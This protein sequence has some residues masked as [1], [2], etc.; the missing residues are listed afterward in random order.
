MTYQ[1]FERRG[2]VA[3][4]PLTPVTLRGATRGDVPVV[5]IA[6]GQRYVT[7]AVDLLS[8]PATRTLRYELV[9]AGQRAILS[10]DAPLPLQGAPFML[11]VPAD[12]LDRGARYSLIIRSTDSTNAVISEY[13]FDVS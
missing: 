3:P 9:R 13:N 11:L 8:P 7:L 10:G 6:N 5:T 4:E 2:D 12:E 1:S